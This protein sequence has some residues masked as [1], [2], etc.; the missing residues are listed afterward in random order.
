MEEDDELAQIRARRMAEMRQQQGAAGGGPPGMRGGRQQNQAEAQ[1]QKEKEEEMKNTILT[2]ILSQEARTRRK[3]CNGNDDTCI[4]KYTSTLPF[5]VNILKAAK[6][7]KAQL[8]ENILIQNAR[9]GAFQGKVSILYAIY[10]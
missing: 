10:T 7:E 3:C 9:M 1:A 8:V 4:I 2:S 6:P 5:L